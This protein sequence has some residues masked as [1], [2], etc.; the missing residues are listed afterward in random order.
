M[1][2][3]IQ[4]I[5]ISLFLFIASTFQIFAEG[6]NPKIFTFS[7]YV[8]DSTT[9]EALIGAT[10]FALEKPG[11]G[12]TTNAYG[13]FSLSLPAGTYNFVVQYLS[14]KRKVIEVDLKSN[15]SMKVEM[16]FQSLALNEVV[17]S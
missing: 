17:I 12:I 16:T 15:I 8:R 11:L 9:G 10:V 1:K 13:Y 4:S 6:E 3:S 7:G 5:A 14:Y 2:K